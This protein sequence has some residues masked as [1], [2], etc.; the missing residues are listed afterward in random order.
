MRRAYL[1]HRRPFARRLTLLAERDERTSLARRDEHARADG[2]LPYASLFG[3]D[4]LAGKLGGDEGYG[5]DKP[6]WAAAG[7]EVLG[8]GGLSATEGLRA[9]LNESSVNHTRM[10]EVRPVRSVRSTAHASRCGSS[11]TDAQA[12]L[13]HADIVGRATGRA[14]L[15]ESISVQRVVRGNGAQ[16][17]N[18]ELLQ[19]ESEFEDRR[20]RIV[21]MYPHALSYALH[22]LAR[23]RTRRCGMAGIPMGRRACPPLVR[24]LARPRP[25]PPHATAARLAPRLW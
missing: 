14:D 15:G 11:T 21:Q 13:R 20:S 10:I 16:E 6:T 22:I 18:R 12:H 9:T 2:T 24:A 1:T 25:R 5:T 17:K 23:A 4:G 19:M 3:R 8:K 7:L